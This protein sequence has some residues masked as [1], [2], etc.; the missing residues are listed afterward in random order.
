MKISYACIL[1]VMAASMILT[2]NASYLILNEGR[3][4]VVF[5]W[6]IKEATIEYEMISDV[7]GWIGVGFS[8][9]GSMNSADMTVMTDTNSVRKYTSLAFETPSENNYNSKS[10][11]VKSS[12]RNQT[13]SWFK[14]SRPLKSCAEYEYNFI[15]APVFILWATGKNRAFL[16]HEAVGSVVTNLVTGGGYVPKSP[17]DVYDIN[18]KEYTIA[19][20][21]NFRNVSSRLNLVSNAEIPS[22]SSYTCHGYDLGVFAPAYM[23]G[24]DVIEDINV[25]HHTTLYS[26]SDNEYSDFMGNS[27]SRNCDGEMSICTRLLSWGRGMGYVDTKGLGLPFGISADRKRRTKLVMEVHTE[28]TGMPVVV[29]IKLRLYTAAKKPPALLGTFA[30]AAPFNHLHI[31]AGTSLNTVVE[32][33]IS[34]LNDV[35]SDTSPST[36]LA[37]HFHGHKL[38]QTFKLR[39]FRSGVELNST[40]SIN[41]F[42]FNMQNLIWFEPNVLLYNTDR[43]VVEAVYDG[44]N[45]AVDVN[46]GFSGN[47]EML[48]VHIVVTPPPLKGY[49]AGGVT[50]DTGE[51]CS[52]IMN[53]VYLWNVS[54]SSPLQT[55]PEQVCTDQKMDFPG[56]G[57]SDRPVIFL[58]FVLSFILP[59]SVRWG[60]S[61]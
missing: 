38:A 39:H 21:V 17:S 3:P 24:Y 5:N 18:L 10:F 57:S 2:I 50:G 25:I 30:I 61:S 11:V 45:A 4:R 35:V 22:G 56:T 55:L 8:K 46:G 52:L 28:N 59:T 9:S 15:D 14:V 13:H 34:C 37:V 31:K 47:D 42:D 27:S 20:S 16:K 7:I 53:K 19:D 26:C 44:K 29:P 36:M 48:S 51:V 43:L 6:E 41:K 23:T 54:S 40:K 33:P 60:V 49:V 12:G 32:F 1:N 58:S